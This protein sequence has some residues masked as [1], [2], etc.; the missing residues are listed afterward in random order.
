[1]SD[2]PRWLDP[3]EMAAW[4]ALIKTQARLMARLDQELEDAHGL[5][6]GEYEVLVHLSETPGGACRMAELAELALVS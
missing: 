4:Q 2:A 3:A 5:S 1:M 6:L